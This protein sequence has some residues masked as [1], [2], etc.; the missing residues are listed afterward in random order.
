[1]IKIC[2]SLVEEQA[3]RVIAA[4]NRAGELGADLLEWRLDITKRAKVEETIQQAPLPVICT[5][6]SVK[7]GGRFSGTRDEQLSLLLEAMEGGSSYVDWEFNS[8]K[9]LPSHLLK[10]REQVIVSYHN[11]D[12]TPAEVDLDSLFQEMAATGAG[13]VKVVTRARRK[14][15]NLE[16][17]RL[18]GKGRRQGLA[19]VAFCLGSLGTISRVA[20]P[21]VGGAFTYAALEPGAEAAPGQ[22][23]VNTV[24]QILELLR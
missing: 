7:Q 17:L 23:S 2:V 21:L 10:M 5:V 4:M 22:L 1:M 15:D 24:Q 9:A 3:D 18:I 13:I 11:F 6:R 20:C 14:E 12:E 19:V 16:V 8:G